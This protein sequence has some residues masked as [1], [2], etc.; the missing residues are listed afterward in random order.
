MRFSLS[1]LLRNT[2]LLMVFVLLTIFSFPST[3]AADHVPLYQCAG[4]GVVGTGGCDSAHT[5]AATRSVGSI[6]QN[7]HFI[8]LGENPAVLEPLIRVQLEEVLQYPLNPGE[9]TLDAAQRLLGT[10]VPQQEEVALAQKEGPVSCA[11]TWN[12]ITSPFTCLW[13]V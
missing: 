6:R 5:L 2:P 13:R 11:G 10:T 4:I 9:G 8:E 1:Q 7:L 12:A 3:A